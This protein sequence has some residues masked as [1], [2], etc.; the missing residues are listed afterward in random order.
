MNLCNHIDVKLS[1][2]IQSYQCTVLLKVILDA[3]DKLM[4]DVKAR[5]N[6]TSAI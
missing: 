4:Q 3:A 2:Y 6:H 5:L 1:E